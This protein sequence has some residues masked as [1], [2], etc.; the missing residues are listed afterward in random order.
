MNTRV[1]LTLSA[2][3]P[4][5]IYRRVDAVAGAVPEV[6][7]IFERAAREVDSGACW[8][9]YSRW[10]LY[11]RFKEQIGGVVGWM[12]P[13]TPAPGADD[14]FACVQALDA[15]LPLPVDEVLS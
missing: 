4:P 10:Q 15:L 8:D 5:R 13:G 11:S 14:F 12:A 3:L 2:T 7:A 1:A 6:A 9:Q